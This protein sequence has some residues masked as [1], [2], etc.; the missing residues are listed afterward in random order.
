MMKL[1]VLVI[2]SVLSAASVGAVCANPAAD[3]FASSVAP[4][5]KKYCVSCHSGEEPEGELDLKSLGPDFTAH[6][7]AWRKVVERLVDCS[8]PPEKKP[9]PTP[10]EREAVIRWIDAGLTVS[11]AS[12]SA[13]D[14]RAR[15]RRLNRIEYVNTLRDLLGAEVDIQSLPADGVASG[16]D[17]V[18]AALDLSS[19]LLERY[20]ETADAALDAVFVGARPEG[21][22]KHI[23]MV[24]LG[25][26]RIYSGRMARYG[27][28]TEIRD[29]EIIF[30]S[31]GQPDKSVEET[32][33]P[34]PGL[35]RY[36]ISANSVRNG[37]G[38]TVVL[39]AGTYGL[40]YPVSRLLGAFDVTDAPTV[41]T[42]TERMSA[43]ESIRL[44]PFSVPTL[45]KPRGEDYQGPGLAVQWIEVEGPLLES[46]PPPAATRLFGS[47]D[48]SKGTLADAEDVLRR[49][50]TR[51]FRRPVVNDELA[52]F[53]GLVQSAL[54][55]KSSFE[56]SLRLGLKAILCSPD[57]LY[58]SAT[59]GKLN[60]F[61]LAARL[62]YFLWS[63]TPDDVLA[64]L[65]TKGEL[66]KPE[67]L[68]QQVERMLADPKANA[69]TENFTGQWLNLRNLTATIPDKEVYPDF[70]DL[71]LLS[72]PQETR[73]F[74]DEILKNDRSALEFVHSDWTML[75]ERLALHYGIPDV[76]GY[77]FKKVSLPADSHRGG[78]MTQ[79]AVLKVTANG[80]NTSPVIRGAWVLDRV[81]GMP[82]P[83]PPKDV[84]AIEPDIRGATTIREQLAKHRSIETCASCHSRIDPA[85]NALENFDVIGGW[86]TAYRTNARLGGKRTTTKIGSR[87]VITAVN[88]E[89]KV[90]AAD[91]LPNGREF[92]S[93][94][95]FKHLILEDPDQFA[96]GLTQRLLIYSTGHRLEV[97]DRTAVDA[98][99]TEVKP[100]NYGF[101]T[102]IHAIVQSPAFRHK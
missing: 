15:L 102:L 38:M 64:E 68:R 101:R 72:M 82:A 89:K 86:Q 21:L 49:F 24:E 70:D 83:P 57:F 37:A 5:V 78:V 41:I 74:F 7:D 84:P 93:I 39:Y 50:A 56:E 33:A 67:V 31:E 98:I 20:L 30:F 40:H 47:T 26:Q 19:T 88:Q 29:H 11:Y 59:P 81:L 92:T 43:K 80:T 96:R 60:D 23:D 3:T 73:S 99:V 58:L 85:G 94:D 44:S 35:Y 13:T 76:T 34:S 95:E 18:D 91:K 14:G 45:Y 42:F 8:M 61:D 9:R 53:M 6:D 97:S 46:W 32:R 17:N 87:K 51:A 69:F 22:N 79:A 66:G 2:A 12:T 52:P 63:S 25:K 100:K 27:E 75:N 77:N 55:K 4:V 71:L 1:A 48:L 28:N 62:S 65:A 54:E 16:F 90:D 36:R 10:A